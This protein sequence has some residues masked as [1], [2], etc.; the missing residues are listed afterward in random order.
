MHRER[1]ARQ[2]NV[3]KRRADARGRVRKGAVAEAG[4]PAGWP[5]LFMSSTVTGEIARHLGVAHY[6]YHFA[7]AKFARLLTRH[8]SAPRMLAM[9][10]YYAGRDAMP[11]APAGAWTHLIFRSTAEIRL[12]KPARNIACFAW[13][14]PVLKTETLPGEHPFLNQA[15]MLNLCD[16]VWVASRFAETVLRAHGVARTHVVPAPIEPPAVPGRAEALRALADLPV[17]PLQ[18]NFAWPEGLQD[19]R[20][21]AAIL[22]LRAGLRALGGRPTIFL[23]ILNPEDARK[24][25]DALVRGFHAHRLAFPDSVLLLKLLRGGDGVTLGRVAGSIMRARLA[26]GSA[27]HDTGILLCHAYL[28]EAEMAALYGLADFFVSA[29]VAEGQNLPLLEAMAAG[30]VAVSTGGTAMEDYLDES[31]AVRIGARVAMNDDPGL[32]GLVAGR[33]FAVA[34]AGG[35]EVAAALA[36][37]RGLSARTRAGMAAAGRARVAACF[38]E[39]AVRALVAARLGTGTAMAAA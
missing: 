16:E 14:F 12:L 13:E 8:F 33:N 2:S 39:D 25:L 23:A 11:E 4:G 31:C 38:G 24:N 7:A 26:G 32:A 3:T 36:T 1:P 15:A 9:P 5:A 21:E 34:R 17:T 6:S 30:C 28:D 19:E 29:S 37:A 18:V 10:E 22:S 35:P 27:M 20:A